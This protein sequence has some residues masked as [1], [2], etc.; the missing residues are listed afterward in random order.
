M[1]D[2]GLILFLACNP[3][4]AAYLLIV[5][6]GSFCLSGEIIMS[7][8]KQFG[9]DKELEKKGITLDYGTFRI[10]AARAG[11]S[12]S[13]FVRT[14][15]FLTKPVRRLIEQEILPVEKER[16]IN[17]RLYAKAVVL[18]WE[19]QDEKGKWK[20]GIEGPDGSILPYTE[21]NVINAFADLPDLFTD[22]QIQ[23]NKMQLFR[24]ADRKADAKN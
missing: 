3:H 23:T 11:S 17:R 2:M 9:T 5:V 6:F 10:T 13:K 15:E 12:N 7:M 14:H 8:Y 20:Q 22:F 21:E 16:E 19:V 4:I 18:N 1:L 24:I